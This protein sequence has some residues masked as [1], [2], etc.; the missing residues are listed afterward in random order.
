ML[1][2]RSN[3]HTHPCAV[4]CGCLNSVELGSRLSCLNSADATFNCRQGRRRVQAPNPKAWNPG[5][6]SVRPV[7]LRE[8][9]GVVVGRGNWLHGQMPRR[10]LRVG[11]IRGPPRNPRTCCRTRLW[12]KLHLEHGP[13]ALSDQIKAVID[14]V[15]AM[16]KASNR[17]MK[18]LG[19]TSH[20]CEGP[21]L[22]SA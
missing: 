4:A 12:R 19:S 7:T 1:S 16:L 10:V 9:L 15:A 22:R 5:C 20:E 17:G 18:L 14:S 8:L 3:K 11:V 21:R 13:G 2:A 6:G